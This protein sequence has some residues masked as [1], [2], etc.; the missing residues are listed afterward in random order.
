M[1]VYFKNPHGNIKFDSYRIYGYLDNR[2][3]TDIPYEI[4][5]QCHDALVDATYRS[6][7]MAKKFGINDFP[8]IAFSYKELAY[9]PFASIKKI[10]WAMFPDK[11]FPVVAREK[12]IFA[13]RKKLRDISPPLLLKEK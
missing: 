13:I 2:P 3:P 12:M 7:Y 4:Y 9:L 10:F 5:K 11:K 6:D 1:L 8:N